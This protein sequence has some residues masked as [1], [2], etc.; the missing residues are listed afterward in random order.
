MLVDLRKDLGANIR[1]IRNTKD[2][3]LPSMNLFN[4][5]PALKIPQPTHIRLRT[6]L[7]ININPTLVIKPTIMVPRNDN[8]DRMR[9]RFQPVQLLLNILN[10]ARVR[11]VTGVDEDVARRDGD[12]FVV[13]VRDTDDFDGGLVAGRVKGAAAQEEDD[14]VEAGDEECEGGGEE[15]VDEGVGIPLVAA[16]EAEPGEEA[17]DESVKA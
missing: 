9:L 8:L 2:V 6:T 14:I 11:E 12:L 7:N 16:T 10:C 3:N 15:V 1:D 17:H 13:R 4:R 5:H